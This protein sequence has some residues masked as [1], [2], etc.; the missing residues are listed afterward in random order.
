[1]KLQYDLQPEMLIYIFWFLRVPMRK[2]PLYRPWQVKQ[3][4]KQKK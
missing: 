1:M 3:E 4:E 2:I